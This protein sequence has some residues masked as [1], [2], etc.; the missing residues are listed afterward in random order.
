MLKA[1]MLIQIKSQLRRL[2][3]LTYVSFGLI[4]LMWAAIAFR[5]AN[6][7]LTHD[8]ALTWQHYTQGSWFTTLTTLGTAGSNDHILNSILIRLT[9]AIF[10]NSELAI[11]LPNVL[12]FGLYAFGCWWLL[13]SLRLKLSFIWVAP[14]VLAPFLLEWFALAR[15]YGLAT[16]LFVVSLAALQHWATT[17][18]S[19]HNWIIW[20]AITAS[21]YANFSML[22][23]YLAVLIVYLTLLFDRYRKSE[24]KWSEIFPVL[25]SILFICYFTVLPLLTLFLRK[26]FYFGGSTN[27]IA[28]TLASMVSTHT[29][30]NHSLQIIAAALVCAATIY[31]V[32][33]VALAWYRREHQFKTAPVVYVFLLVIILI[34]LA[35]YATKQLLP[36]ERA[37]IW[38]YPLA[39]LAFYAIVRKFPQRYSTKLLGWTICF[40][41]AWFSLANWATNF[42][43]THTQVWVYDAEAKY[44]V[45]LL[46]ELTLET[47]KPVIVDWVLAPS[48]NYYC[49]IYALA[50]EWQS[51]TPLDLQNRKVY[52]DQYLVLSR[53]SI[54]MSDQNPNLRLILR[55]DVSQTSVYYH[56]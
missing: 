29:Y 14:L 44:V 2:H 53:Y 39:V 37:A 3:P 45:Q 18:N 34:N 47:T 12:A 26:E 21:F 32:I 17:N 43:L 16:A 42:N 8:E 49:Q 23:G 15:G 11:R 35:F 1:N 55:F 31:A 40:S 10:G 33:T 28:D 24:L 56:L 7:S 54:E 22:Y 50:C 30:A 27:F 51:I 48:L 38:L 4:L 46:P 41:L 13:R 52:K 5:A 6:L 25:F 19:R 20:I 36:V 9:T